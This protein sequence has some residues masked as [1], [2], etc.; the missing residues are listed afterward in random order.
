MTFK[1]L[2][3]GVSYSDRIIREVR[4]VCAA[5]GTL[6]RA[7]SEPK[8]QQQHLSLCETISGLSVEGRARSERF[9]PVGA[10]PCP[11]LC[12]PIGDSRPGLGAS[13]CDTPAWLSLAP[14]GGW[15]TFRK[16]Q[17]N[18][19]AV[20]V[21]VYRPCSYESQWVWKL[22]TSD[23]GTLSM[24]LTRVCAFSVY[25]VLVALSLGRHL[26]YFRCELKLRS[27]CHVKQPSVRQACFWFWIKTVIITKVH[28]SIE[29][30]FLQ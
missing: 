25:R 9:P 5:G 11:G 27:C 12:V 24:L 2:L 21:Q 28:K 30:Y 16:K 23:T 20:G 4:C 15:C 3:C 29:K 8:L 18:M 1:V 13:P 17:T 26:A 7:L 22:G 10:G 14:K 19:E 6:A